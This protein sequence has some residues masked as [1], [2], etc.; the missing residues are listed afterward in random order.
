M[1]QNTKSPMNTTCSRFIPE[2]DSKFEICF[3]KNVD[4]LKK[5]IWKYDFKPWFDIT[6]T[7]LLITSIWLN[8]DE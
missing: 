6:E 3:K 1:I 2:K 7:I 5:K 8:I 4:K